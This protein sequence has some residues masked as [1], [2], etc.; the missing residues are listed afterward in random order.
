VLEK[1]SRAILKLPNKKDRSAVEVAE[2]AL[3]AEKNESR[4]K[5][6]R[7]RLTVERLRRQI[8][9]LQ[10][11]WR[12]VWMFTHCDGECKTVKYDI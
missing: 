1:Q 7:H 3:E 6:A 10:V 4:A 9:E 2:A 12:R 11:G 8:V 5:D